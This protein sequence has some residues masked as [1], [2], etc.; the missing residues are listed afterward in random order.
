MA[1]KYLNATE[2]SIAL[3]LGGFLG[4]LDAT[5]DV[6][7]KLKRSKD[8]LK[9]ARTTRSFLNKTLESIVEDMDDEQVLKIFGGTVS[10]TKNNGE[11]SKSTVTRIK[12]D[13]DNIQILLKLKDE[14]IRE[15]KKLEAQPGIIAVDQDDLDQIL[16]FASYSCDLCESAGDDVKTCPYRKLFIKYDAVPINTEPGDT[17]CPFRKG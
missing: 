10:I 5:I 13:I 15:A 12:G 4:F 8:L 7:A 11:G 9:N 16:N 2:K 3:T 6:W 1:K 17:G 14:A